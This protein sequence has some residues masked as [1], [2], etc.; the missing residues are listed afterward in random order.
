[1]NAIN[2][3]QYEN[4]IKQ[5]AW[6]W[7]H[8]SKIE[9]KELLSEGN[10]AYC[11]AKDSYDENKSKFSTWLWHTVDLHLRAFVQK[12]CQSK[13]IN[14]QAY[15]QHENRGLAHYDS[16]FFKLFSHFSEE[17]KQV[18]EII[19]NSPNEFLDIANWNT[20]SISI[21]KFT[22]HLYEYEIP[23]KKSSRIFKE[24]KTV[25]ASI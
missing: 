10:V 6:A 22:D 4:L 1:M 24:I 18:I 21:S 2:Y 12:E 5:L 3:K 16:Y 25:L 19:L 20:G 14:Q 9:F 23:W 8:R 13:R 11:I 17:A 7:H 15:N